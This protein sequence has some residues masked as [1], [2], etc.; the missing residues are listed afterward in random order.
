MKL[1][2]MEKQSIPATLKEAAIFK[3][4]KESNTMSDIGLKLVLKNKDF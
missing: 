2:M 4:R 3:G 1:A